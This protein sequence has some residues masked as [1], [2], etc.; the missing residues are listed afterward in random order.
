MCIRC[1]TVEAADY[2]LL[3]Q[4]MLATAVALE[5]DKGVFSK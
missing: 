3:L 1:D 5:R 4:Q 2:A